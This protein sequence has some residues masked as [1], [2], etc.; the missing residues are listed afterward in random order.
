MD[1]L[2]RRNMM[3]GDRA[4]KKYYIKA[5]QDVKTFDTGILTS[6][7]GRIEIQFLLNSYSA[8]N[9]CGIIGGRT[10]YNTADAISLNYNTAQKMV[11]FCIGGTVVDRAWFCDF[12][13]WHT[14]R[15]DATSQICSLDGGDGKS[16]GQVVGSSKTIHVFYVP[17]ETTLVFRGGIASFKIWD[18]SGNLVWDAEP[19][20]VDSQAGFINKV[21][22]TTMLSPNC[23]MLEM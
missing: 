14:F 7:A 18:K 21:D 11:G 4:A 1:L 15:W 19:T 3:Q 17:A 16:T 20:S 6:D 22:S 8:A 10:R 2:R 13:T 12:N 5:N 9:W 23:E